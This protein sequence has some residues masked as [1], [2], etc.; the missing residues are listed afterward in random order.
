MRRSNKHFYRRIF[1]ITTIFVTTQTYPANYSLEEHKK[2]HQLGRPLAPPTDP[3]NSYAGNKIAQKFGKILFFDKRL[4]RNGD[5]SCAT[6]H[7]PDSYFTDG[8][9]YFN[10]RLGEFRRTPSLLNTCQNRWFMWDGRA[11]SVWAQALFPLREGG[12][13]GL[14][15]QGILEMLRGDQDLSQYVKLLSGVDLKEARHESGLDEKMLILVAKSIAA[16][17]CT[18]TSQSSK[19]DQYVKWMNSAD[20]L[21][22]KPISDSAERGLKIFIRDNSCISCHNGPLFTNGEFHDIG[23]PDQSLSGQS[24]GGRYAGILELL[25]SEYRADGAYSDAP[26][27][28]RGRR[29]KFVIQSQSLRRA[30]KTPSLRNVAKRAPYSH[31][32]QIASLESMLQHYASFKPDEHPHSEKVLGNMQLTEGDI[33]DLTNFLNTLTD[34]T[35]S[36][37]KER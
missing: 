1:A 20:K 13:L 14:G 23:I 37:V 21:R 17:E 4:S 28:I 19:F 35:P 31:T 34:D 18:L 2:L 5:T 12:E 27:S 8:K 15:K 16:F 26:L 7:K 9:S 3:T 32:G 25:A 30:F 36:T 11:D 6:C 33:R 10:T 22:P 29:T 24:A